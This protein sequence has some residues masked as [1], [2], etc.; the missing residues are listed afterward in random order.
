[1]DFY[2]RAPG[3]PHR[4]NCVLSCLSSFCYGHTLF[5]LHSLLLTVPFLPSLLKKHV[6][7]LSLILIL[8]ES[9]ERIDSYL[10]LPQARPFPES[11][12][13]QGAL[14]GKTVDAV[15]LPS[16]WGIISPHKTVPFRGLQ[17]S[18]GSLSFLITVFKL[19]GYIEKASVGI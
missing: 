2:I 4:Y 6:W 13:H 7:K 17:V 12:G 10:V 19:Y 15:P 16:S 18:L 11:C 3:T 1:M 8:D 9:R 5:P 14:P